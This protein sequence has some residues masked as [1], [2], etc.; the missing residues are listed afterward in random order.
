[1]RAGRLNQQVGIAVLAIADGVPI[2]WEPCAA[3]LDRVAQLHSTG[4]SGA[5]SKRALR[6]SPSSESLEG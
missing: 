5:E 2:E 3:T 1:M 4:P 6:Q